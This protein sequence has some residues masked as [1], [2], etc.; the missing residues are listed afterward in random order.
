MKKTTA[1]LLLLAAAYAQ[2]QE[3]VTFM[4]QWTAQAQF[5]GY[6]VA[7]EKGFYA[8]AGLKVTI[9]HVSTSTSKSSLEHVLDGSVDICTGQLI[10]GMIYR[11]KGKDLINV[12]QTSQ[13][14]SLMCV[15]NKPFSDINDMDGMR[16]ARWKAGFGETADLFCQEYGF[17]N[18]EW[19]YFASGINLFVSKAVDATLCYS[20][21]EYLDLLFARGEIPAGNVLEFGKFGFNV[22][23]DAIMTTERYYNEHKEA[24]DKFKEASIRGWNYAREHPE[25]AIDIVMDYARSNNITTNRIHQKLMLEKV[26]EQQVNHDSGTADFQH[27]SKEM[28]QNLN[29]EMAGIGFI[30]NYVNYSDF[31]K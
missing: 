9:Q 14:C 1:A 6:Y 5:A 25:E 21:S 31:L 20:Y 13:N 12:L 19:I 30:S 2:A 7:Q 8:D 10:Q 28:F 4:P 16:I 26:L 22:P 15:F 29:E 11:D 17:K 18:I 23:E 3:K 27:M 24:V